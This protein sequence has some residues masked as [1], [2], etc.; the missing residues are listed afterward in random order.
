MRILAVVSPVRRNVM[1][2]S[3]LTTYG[4]VVYVA[5]PGADALA[6]LETQPFD[7]CLLEWTL[8]KGGSDGLDLLRE[9]HS[10]WPEMR[11]IAMGEEATGACLAATEGA[12]SF[13]DLPIELAELHSK[14][15]TIVP[16]SRTRSD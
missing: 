7:M 2:V 9:I 10:R 13:V 6:M 16:E 8:A 3:G 14:I 12:A 15:L 1:L 4:H 11:V 5:R